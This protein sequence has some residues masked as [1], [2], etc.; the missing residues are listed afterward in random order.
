MEKWSCTGSSFARFAFVGLVTAGHQRRFG[1]RPKH[2][3]QHREHFQ[4]QVR[5]EKGKKRET[6]KTEHMIRAH[7]YHIQG[8]IHL[9]RSVRHL[10]PVHCPLYKPSWSDG[11]RLGGESEAA[12]SVC[13]LTVRQINGTEECDLS[14][15]SPGIE[16]L[17]RL[18]L[19]WMHLLVVCFR[20]RQRPGGTM[21]ETES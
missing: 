16:G 1:F 10:F 19:L 15:T 17:R 7:M 9:D 5:T 2:A 20:P 4:R 21:R 6:E 11:V 14:C 8:K 18:L 3:W 13:S 12:P